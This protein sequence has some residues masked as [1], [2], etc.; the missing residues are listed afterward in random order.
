MDESR[1]DFLAGARLA[2]NQDGGVR[3][4]DQGRLA[5]HIHHSADSPTT[6]R[7]V[8]AF[9]RSTPRLPARIPAMCALAINVMSRAVE[10]AVG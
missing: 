3:R 5:Q 6:C 9:T 8:A 2:G 10:L 7:C 4:G 1:H